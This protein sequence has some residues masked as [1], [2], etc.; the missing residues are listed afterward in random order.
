MTWTIYAFG[1]GD[2][3]ANVLTAVALLVNGA[4]G[5]LTRAAALV[6]LLVALGMTAVRAIDWPRF[7]GWFV[8]FAL[9]FVSL[10]QL[11]VAVAVEDV[12]DSRIPPRIVGDVPL[13]VALPAAAASQISYQLTN[14]ATA[15]QLNG[16][17]GGDVLLRPTAN[18]QALLESA[19]APGDLH[20][21]LVNY[22]HDCVV[23]EGSGISQVLAANNPDL[24]AAIQSNDFGNMVP[25]IV[26]GQEAGALSC[27]DMYT[28][29][30]T[31][32]LAPP[33]EGQ[34]AG[35]D[36]TLRGLK[37]R[38]LGGRSLVTPG[39]TVPP[40][41]SGPL[42][43]AWAALQPSLDALHLNN[44]GAVSPEQIFTTVIIAKSWHEAQMDLAREH[45]DP[46]SA[47][48]IANDAL[49]KQL[50]IQAQTGREVA[51]AGLLRQ[52]RALADGLV[53]LGAPILLALAVTPFVWRAL[54][55]Y[56]RL[57]VWLMLW[58]PIQAIVHFIV[59]GVAVSDVTAAGTAITLGT[60]DDVYRQIVQANATGYDVMI[61]V[62]G[63]A[64]AL[65]WGGV[66]AI[67]G[68]LGGAAGGVLATG[69]GLRQRVE[70]GEEVTAS[71]FAKSAAL[72]DP[73]KRP[74]N[75][76]GIGADDWQRHWN[77]TAVTRGLS[78]TTVRPGDGRMMTVMKD[79]SIKIASPTQEVSITPEGHKSGWQV[80]DQTVT[81]QTP[82]GS[83]TVPQGAFVRW[84]GNGADV[85]LPSME[86]PLT[87]QL[88]KP[89]GVF[90]QDPN[91]PGGFGK[92]TQTTWE[93]TL[94]GLT[95][96]AVQSPDGTIS[97]RI[98]GRTDLRVETAGGRSFE[99]AGTI[100][101]AAVATPDGRGGHEVQ[102]AQ[103][104]VDYIGPDGQHHVEDGLLRVP[105]HVTPDPDN[106][107]KKIA[108][109]TLFRPYAGSASNIVRANTASPITIGEVRGTVT[110]ETVTGPDGAQVTQAEFTLDNGLTYK[111]FIPSDAKP[112]RDGKVTVAGQVDGVLRRTRV[113]G[114]GLPEGTVV[115]LPVNH[116]AVLV[117]I[118]AGKFDPE[119]LARA[120]EQ[121]RVR[122]LTAQVPDPDDPT[123]TMNLTVNDLLPFGSPA[124]EVGVPTITVDGQ[125]YA[126]PAIPRPADAGPTALV[127]SAGSATT[128]PV[129]IALGHADWKGHVEAV[130][131]TKVTS[132]G[133]G[134]Q[135]LSAYRANMYYVSPSGQQ[136]YLGFGDVTAM[137]RDNGEWALQ[138]LNAQRGSFVAEKHK[139]EATVTERVAKGVFANVTRTVDLATGR[140]VTSKQEIGVREDNVEAVQKAFGSG[141]VRMQPGGTL[142]ITNDG[143]VTYEGPAVVT[144]SVPHP[145]TGKPSKVTA[146]VQARL[147]GV[148]DPKTGKAAFRAGEIGGVIEGSASTASMP[149][150]VRDRI[151]RELGP[152]RHGQVR[153]ALGADG[154]ALV[155]RTSAGDSAEVRQNVVDVSKQAFTRTE[156]AYQIDPATARNLAQRGDHRL[157][158]DVLDRGLP[159][160]QEQRALAQVHALME[161]LDLFYQRQGSS[162]DAVG[163]S[164]D[165]SAVKDLARKGVAKVAAK[166]GSKDAEE[167]VEKVFDSLKFYEV[168]YQSEDQK[169]VNLLA[170]QLL[171][172]YYTA[173]ELAAQAAARSPHDPNAYARTF[174]DA[175]SKGVQEVVGDALE[176]VKDRGRFSFG[177]THLIGRAGTQAEK[178]ISS[179]RETAGGA[180]P[181]AGS[182]PAEAGVGPLSGLFNAPGALSSWE[183]V[184]TE[185]S[186]AARPEPPAPSVLE[187]RRPEP[188][189]N[190]PPQEPSAAPADSPP[191]AAAPGQPAPPQNT[192]SAGAGSARPATPRAG[193]GRS[194]TLAELVDQLPEPERRRFWAAIETDAKLYWQGVSDEPAFRRGVALSM[195]T[196]VPH[197]DAGVRTRLAD[198]IVET[199]KASGPVGTAPEATQDHAAAS[200]AAPAPA[201]QP[202]PEKP[203]SAAAG[204]AAAPAQ[205]AGEPTA[206]ESARTA[207][208][209]AN[210]A[211]PG[212][213][214]PAGP[215]RVEPSAAAAPR[216]RDV[217][218]AQPRPHARN[219]AAD[220][221]PNDQIARVRAR[222]DDLF[223]KYEAYAPVVA[224]YLAGMITR[225]ELME[226]I[227]RID[228][229]VAGKRIYMAGLAEPLDFTGY[230]PAG[231]DDSR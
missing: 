85:E 145:E 89:R 217:P 43:D 99:T 213:P 206:P 63:I 25:L 76:T 208:A 104:R 7:A 91:A 106:P 158:W 57:F 51:K 165:P 137:R 164:L 68:V 30:L 28:T 154:Q 34:D 86:D 52:I 147:E 45:R 9:V 50:E 15:L 180:P 96:Q 222:G 84:T 71:A 124:G 60:L 136:T 198:A 92:L 58:G 169:R 90:A 201:P 207:P 6:G 64:L 41:G 19:L 94:K 65:A 113:V 8:G 155:M 102:V 22:L 66:G 204:Q 211:G 149:A 200:S 59:M 97:Y 152:G 168:S 181:E 192:P 69:T 210:A 116:A 14:L 21:N 203:N 175:Y 134:S 18:V 162:T 226:R 61:A 227:Y 225:E 179:L 79:G 157:A 186:Q 53:Y 146:P 44:A 212:A 216:E 126:F 56:A 38:L 141:P 159:G 123:R 40:C 10:I 17:L 185:Q 95:Y 142:T 93:T 37:C 32:R 31:P 67:G 39:G 1:D 199:L 55:L 187:G 220:S 120:L 109:L 101:A 74:P 107:E 125:E 161:S 122:A 205:S 177:S 110:M 215:G 16:E 153:L 166:L 24:F 195:A 33:T 133:D 151:E 221:A 129:R 42:S 196:Y 193:A 223:D 127:S 35:L 148:K 27:A 135:Q 112:D 172:A 183:P 36:A 78:G 105:G 182:G 48:A 73:L 190:G 117:Q 83:Y 194:G 62:P 219:G 188:D 171:A 115:D 100:H 82:A 167:I 98:Q 108:G 81:V 3:L 178:L 229:S 230:R 176:S 197:L 47:M 2:L 70:A 119:T 174:E 4:L 11:R 231:Q 121:A 144:L 139:L 46:A 184:P 218:S 12:V 13:I 72:A 5:S 118:P 23:R 138:N 150:W 130:G 143:R 114:G 189:P 87:H 202:A 163:Y 224:Q 103:A 228:P 80:L 88:V 160:T 29:V 191:R 132:R 170:H 173:D 214:S 128:E 20:A 156:G 111:L 209:S 77:T 54:G 75:M 26:N 131:E 140:V 49:L